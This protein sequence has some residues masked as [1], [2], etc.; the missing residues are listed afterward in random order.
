MFE[1]LR[2]FTYAA[3]H[4]LVERLNMRSP[5]LLVPAVLLAG[6]ASTAQLEEL[7]DKVD[8]MEKRIVDLEARPVSSGK[9][10]LSSADEAKAGDLARAMID[11]FRKGDFEKAQGSMKELRGKY[12]ASQAY[13]DR[14]VQK[15]ATQLSVIGLKVAS[16]PKPEKWYKGSDAAL[17]VSSGTTLVVFWEEW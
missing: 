10:G 11:S 9:E 14:G 2:Q 15:Y 4:T 12:A 8:A 6:C 5:I 17:D 16:I 3:V 1:I 13:R 7:V